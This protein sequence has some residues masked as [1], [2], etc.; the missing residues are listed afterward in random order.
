MNVLKKGV[1]GRVLAERLVVRPVSEEVVWLVRAVAGD[2]I[3]GK[4]EEA[5]AADWEPRGRPGGTP[6][7]D[8]PE[9][10]LVSNIGLFGVEELGTPSSH[11]LLLLPDLPCI[12]AVWFFPL[13]SAMVTSN[14]A[15]RNLQDFPRRGPSESALHVNTR[16][17]VSAI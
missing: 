5:G 6:V 8:L 12:L 7:K 11:T 1:L 2:K 17:Q 16:L 14:G 9:E 4:R 3:Q 10:V 15:L 13:L